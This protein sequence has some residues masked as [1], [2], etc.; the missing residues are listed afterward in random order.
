MADKRT[1]IDELNEQLE[2]FLKTNKEFYKEIEKTYSSLELYK[3]QLDAQV[4][5]QSE[6]NEIVEKTTESLDE[7]GKALLKVM[8]EKQKLLEVERELNEA[9]ADQEKMLGRV[10]AL[11]SKVTSTTEAFT[12]VNVTMLGSL[13]SIGQT[14]KEFAMALDE[15]QVG[16][17]RSTGFATRYTKNFQE[18]GK[19]FRRSGLGIEDLGQSI[20]SLS[21]NFAG[22]DTLSENNRNNLIKLSADAK[23]LGMD[24]DDFSGVIDKLN[25]AFG[26]TGASSLK[27][28]GDIQEIAFKTG[29]SINRVGK[30]LVE[31][32][33]DLAR[34]GA[35]GIKVFEKLSI[36]ARSLGL[37]VKQAFD[38]SEL[39]D[40]FE[41]A[42]NVAGRLNAQLG[43]Q[44][45]SVELMKASSD[46]RL[47]ILRQEFKL[48]GMD[49]KTAG[50][51]QRQMIASILGVDVETAGRLLG[52]GADIKQFQKEEKITQEQVV[53]AQQ[54]AAA[55]SEELKDAIVNYFGGPDGI[56]SA[57]K[58]FSRFTMNNAGGLTQTG[59]G[60]SAGIAIGGTLLAAKGLPFMKSMMARRIAGVSP[61]EL[62]KQ[63]G[64][65]MKG[66]AT[67]AA[68]KVVHAG[69]NYTMGGA[70]R[71]ADVVGGA[72]APAASTATRAGTRVVSDVATKGAVTAAGKAGLGKMLGRAI[73]GVGFAIGA[74]GAYDRAKRGDYGGALAELGIGALSFVP[75][76]GGLVASLGGYAAL[77]ARDTAKSTREMNERNMAMQGG[78]AAGMPS[79]IVIKELIV[80]SVVELE[81]NKLGETV[82]TYIKQNAEVVQNIIERPLQP[83][84]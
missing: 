73:P 18:M 79:E 3:R 72:A 13:T 43:L 29:R 10:N 74:M 57:L 61:K 56:I 27:A 16:L 49:F 6:Y 48:K 42:A 75:G 82:K 2:L 4:I 71:M 19:A 28:F 65:A 67:A 46:E 62:T 31:L 1:D 47:D 26:Q 70:K 64:T 84:Q 55:A 52:E 68:P 58:S 78:Q 7:K 76:V 39:F 63:V 45:N 37:G 51:R 60:V 33:P 12:G 20:S 34:F 38:I 11:Y 41:S 8:Q 83:T 66:S 30:D 21:N 32:G 77:A 59:V 36:R 81:G 14:A 15:Q 80:H 22:F 17:R 50:R 53:S 24:F 35:E 54:L 40:T 23:N 44:L 69:T 25:Y 9:L 5:S